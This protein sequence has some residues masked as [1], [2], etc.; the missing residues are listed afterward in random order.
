ML[1][2]LV[3]LFIFLIVKVIYMGAHK[4]IQPG[5]FNQLSIAD[6]QKVT[7][8]HGLW[9][10]INDI[11]D[12]RALYSVWMFFI[13]EATVFTIY[14]WERKTW[15]LVT[16][17][18]RWSLALSII[19]F[20][21]YLLLLVWNFIVG[22][23]NDAARETTNFKRRW[24]F[25]YEGLEKGFLQRIFQFVQYLIYFLWALFLVVLY[26]SAVAQ[27]ILHIILIFILFIYVLVFRPALTSF[28]K[29]EQ[30]GIHFFLFLTQV[31]IIVLLFDDDRKHMSGKS[32]WRMG[33]AVAF[34]MFFI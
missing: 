11:F 19:Y 5:V 24:G 15:H 10:R 20:V 12:Q 17:L 21:I 29:M 4:K 28:W 6:K 3:F 22:S 1:L 26:P 9:R 25:V 23:K 8:S 27:G 2:Q 7:K 30:I 14:N 34:F 32:R 16:S 33:Y 18:F 13:V 31:L